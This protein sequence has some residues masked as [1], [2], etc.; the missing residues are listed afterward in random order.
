MS[1]CYNNVNIITTNYDRYIEYCCDICGV[2]ID[3]RFNGMYLKSLRTNELKKKDVVNLLKVHGSLDTFHRSK[4]KR[5]FA[6][7]CNITFPMD[8]SLKS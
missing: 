3:N 1:T 7:L 4:Q 6:F 5:V 2:E 8:L